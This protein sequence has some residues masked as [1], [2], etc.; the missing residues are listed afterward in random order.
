MF[1]LFYIFSSLE[2]WSVNHTAMYENSE[3][4]AFKNMK[5]LGEIFGNWPNYLL[6]INVYK[7]LE[8]YW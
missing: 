6:G 3:L 8:F 1:I 5:L 7:T 4:K 2:I